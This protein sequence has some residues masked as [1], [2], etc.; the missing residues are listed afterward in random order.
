MGR[1]LY[2]QQHTW[3]S[4]IPG[5]SWLSK[6]KVSTFFLH[7]TSHNLPSCGVPCQ[8]FL[9]DS[10]ILRI[11]LLTAAMHSIIGTFIYLFCLWSDQNLKVDDSKGSPGRQPGSSEP[12]L[13]SHTC[14]KR[15]AVS[16]TPREG[17]RGECSR[18]GPSDVLGQPCRGF[19]IQVRKGKD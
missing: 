1:V 2:A 19:S 8:F 3:S 12:L 7:T 13:L 10:V 15:E 4:F 9:W 6:V 17:M 14:S 11:P 18:S 16:V 5:P